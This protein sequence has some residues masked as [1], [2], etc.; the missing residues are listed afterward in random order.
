MIRADELAPWH[1]GNAYLED[2]RRRSAEIISGA[3]QA[4]ES[5]RLRGFEDGRRAGVED[6]V[7]LVAN[8]KAKADAFMARLEADLADV[9]VEI[10]REIL[11]PFEA[12]D[13]AARAVIKALETMRSHAQLTVRIAPDDVVELRARLA[14]L[15]GPTD[16]AA[17]RVEPDQDLGTGRCL[18]V[19]EFG[20]VDVTIETQLQLMAQGLQ[21]IGRTAAP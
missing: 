9:V 11:A 7:R 15:V 4:Y 8:T 21:A 13:L 10:L 19:S 20:Q 6:A 14:A 12:G 5:E 2:A 16:H 18:L 17:I 3:Q 1:D